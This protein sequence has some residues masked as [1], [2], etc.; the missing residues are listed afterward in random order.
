[1]CSYSFAALVIFKIHIGPH[2]VRFSLVKRRDCQLSGA[3]AVGNGK[4]SLKIVWPK[5]RVCLQTQDK[6]R[7]V[8]RA[9]ILSLH[10]ITGKGYGNVWSPI[11]YTR[12]RDAY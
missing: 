10:I 7:L 2:S 6:R 9:V 8:K 3:L 1:M 5:C 12:K 11:S 4:W